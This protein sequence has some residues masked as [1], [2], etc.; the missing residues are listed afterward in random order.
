MDKNNSQ[1]EVK[2]L[3]F[4]FLLAIAALGLGFNKKQDFSNAALGDLTS[5][6]EARDNK[7]KVIHTVRQENEGINDMPFS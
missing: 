4:C 7:L 3:I 1:T 5:P 2:L 6:Y